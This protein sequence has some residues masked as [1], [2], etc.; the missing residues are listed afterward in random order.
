MAKLTARGVE[1]VTKSGRYVDGEGLCLMVG[2]S[3]AEKW[4]L[5]YQVAGRRRDMGLACP[6]HRDL[7]QLS[8]VSRPVVGRPGAFGSF[9]PS[10]GS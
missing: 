2:D 5:R 3:G 1:T 6:I 8:S 7:A 9:S 4:V 10:F